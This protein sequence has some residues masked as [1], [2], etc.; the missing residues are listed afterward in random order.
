MAAER[1]PVDWAGS[2]AVV[3]GCAAF[4]AAGVVGALVYRAICRAQMLM[5][6]PMA[7]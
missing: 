3:W 6:S 4:G 7:N 1:F 5:E 2:G